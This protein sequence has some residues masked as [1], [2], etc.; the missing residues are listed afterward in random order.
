MKGKNAVIAAIT[1]DKNGYIWFRYSKVKGAF[2]LCPESRQINSYRPGIQNEN[3]PDGVFVS[4][5]SDSKGNFW[6][7]TSKGLCKIAPD[8]QLTNYYETWPFQNDEDANVIIS[9]FEHSNGSVWV[10]TKNGAFIY[11]KQ[12]HAFKKIKDKNLRNSHIRF[13]I[14]DEQG[15]VWISCRSAT[16][17]FDMESEKVFIANRT[18]DNRVIGNMTNITS[19]EDE[20]GR[21]WFGSS[22]KGIWVYDPHSLKIS[23]PTPGENEAEKILNAPVWA[24]LERNGQLYAGTSTYGLYSIHLKNNTLSKHPFTLEENPNNLFIRSVL[25]AGNGKLWIA[26]AVGEIF[27]FDPLNNQFKR[28]ISY[29]EDMFLYSVRKLL[30][31]GDYI[32]IAGWYGL[33]RINKETLRHSKITIK[34]TENKDIRALNTLY[35]DSKGNIWIGTVYDGIIIYNTKTQEKKFIKVNETKNTLSSNNILS[36]LETR[37]GTMWIG[38]VSG[39]NSIR[40]QQDS[41]LTI[42]YKTIRD[43]LPN[44]TVYGMEEDEKGHIWII[45]NNGLTEYNPKTDLFYNYDMADGLVYRE[46]NA[47]ASFKGSN[48]ILYFGNIGGIVA[49]DPK[50]IKRN[51]HVPDVIITHLKINDNDLNVDSMGILKKNIQY[52]EKVSLN[53]KQNDIT[54]E[55]TALDYSFIKKNQY[56]YMLEGYDNEWKKSKN[57]IAS[58]TNLPPGDY[59]FKVKASNND[60]IWSNKITELKISIEPPFWQT[61]LFITISVMISIIIITGIIKLRIQK[62]KKSHAKLE[63]IVSERTEEIRERNEEILSQN[64]EIEHQKE[65]ILRQKKFAEEANKAKSIFLANM[66]HEI[67]TPLNAII[68]FTDLLLDEKPSESQKEY[69]SAVETSGRT[70][71]SIINDILDFSKIEAQKIQLNPERNNIRSFLQNIQKVFSVLVAEKGIDFRIEINKKLPNILIFDSHRLKQVLNNLIGNAIKFTDKGFIKISVDYEERNDDKI[72]LL[73]EVEDTGKGILPDHQ[74][75]I[76]DAFEQESSSTSGKYGGT[77]LGLAISKQLVSLM[78]GEITLKSEPNKGSVFK[79]SLKEIEKSYEKEEDNKQEDFKKYESTVFENAHIVIA[80][81]IRFNRILLNALFTKTKIR[82]TEASNGKEV[83]ELLEKEK[84]DLILMDIKMPVMDGEETTRIIKSNPTYSSIPV[85]ALTASVLKEE[86]KPLEELFDSYITKP[87]KKGELF[88]E[89]RKYLPFA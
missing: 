66:S 58:Y 19:F 52:T 45:T 44:N 36:F 20:S 25:D 11:S 21:L 49:V 46:F 10:G 33:S 15:N 37:D 50:K 61:W 54:F 30:D 23:I 53:Y 81:D 79:V 24:I 17:V 87:Y 84:P 71:L 73:I 42:D 59:V 12:E 40:F 80:D 47:D 60:G 35:N 83:L 5:L 69:L 41:I 57:R 67:R 76:F 82:T 14:E 1:G 56:L 16:Y 68:G 9:I 89:L 7:G 77:G 2:R 18:F 75:R 28:V 34:N 88:F 6:V 26:N 74:K 72:D 55:F 48:G 13:F 32:W 86:N 70:L 62:I 31:F 78:N 29:K 4:F 22:E 27:L 65:I 85:I 38:T 3:Y 63:Q 8:G 64:K 43:G 39:L 51:P